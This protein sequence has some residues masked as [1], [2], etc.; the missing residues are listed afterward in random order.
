M[1]IAF[2]AIILVLLG[3]RGG[4]ESNSSV[5]GEA[6][7]HTYDVKM[8]AL[9]KGKWN[10]I[11]VGGRARC[12][13]G[14]PFG[15]F[16]RPGDPSKFVIEYMGG[17]MCFDS[18]SCMRT[19]TSR[20]TITT[21]N[22][23]LMRSGFKLVNSGK[24]KPYG[25]YDH[26]NQRNPVRGFTHIFVPYCTGDIHWGNQDVLH[27]AS[28]LFRHRGGVN[29]GTVLEWIK[30]E[31]PASNV[32]RALVTGCSAGSYG[33]ILWAPHVVRAYPNAKVVQCGDSGAGVIKRSWMHHVED[34]WRISRGGAIPDWIPGL[35]ITR[36]NIINWNVTDIYKRIAGHYT[37]ATFSQF[38]Y[39]KD[40]SQLSF[41]QLTG[42]AHANYTTWRGHLV[43][44][45]NDIQRASP[46]FDTYTVDNTGPKARPKHCV[47][48]SND[49][50]KVSVNGESFT[51]WLQQ[52]IEGKATPIRP[53][54]KSRR[55]QHQGSSAKMAP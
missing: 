40:N 36:G 35:P 55:T 37:N 15:F 13:S 49:M 20:A 54:R 51:Q 5:T 12:G 34:T 25:I 29:A 14:L 8:S 52:L 30:R 1:A 24:M 46:N 42:A 11:V 41:F 31:I 43:S 53:G 6:P 27:D 39:E 44:S 28:L 3:R 45:L 2:V 10:E 26:G 22:Y 4:G 48:N 19:T 33:S 9:T 47:I 23:N 50:Y 32:K 7:T 17:G 21:S 18:A 38:N 16:V